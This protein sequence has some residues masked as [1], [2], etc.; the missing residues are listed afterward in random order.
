[1]CLKPQQ[2]STPVTNITSWIFLLTFSVWAELCCERGWAP[3]SC[4]VLP[5]AVG[6]GPDK[7]LPI[8][9]TFVQ[10]AFCGCSHERNLMPGLR[11]CV[12]GSRTVVA[13]F[14]GDLMQFAA[15]VQPAPT[16]IGQL[17]E[18]FHKAGRDLRT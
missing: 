11:I 2:P 4:E 7:V 13:M 12:Q 5:A 16:S 3:A 18:V 14:I 6:L 8:V 17:W 10:K 9:R 1:M 15:T